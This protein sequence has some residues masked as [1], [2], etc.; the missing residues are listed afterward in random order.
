M[1]HCPKCGVENAEEA[2]VCS[3][4][5]A[6]L[7]TR[8]P[9]DGVTANKQDPEPERASG[10]TSCIRIFRG[11]TAQMEADLAKNVLEQEGIPCALPGEEM[12]AVLPGVDVVQLLVRQE[13][14]EEATEILK[15]FF[16]LPQP[17]ASEEPSA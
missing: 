5:G 17:L 7:P 9:P 2:T 4:C 3:V 16:D 13:D 14:A 10:E 8:R 12:A 1:A 15:D 6:A 11:P